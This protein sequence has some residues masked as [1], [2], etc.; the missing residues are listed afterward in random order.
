MNQAA[1][2][3]Q[4]MLEQVNQSKRVTKRLVSAALLTVML[5]GVSLPAN[6]VPYEKNDAGRVQT[7]ERYDQIQENTG[8]MNG[9]DAVDP[10][11]DTNE[12][13]AQALS[14]IAKRRQAQASDPLEPAR[15]AVSDMKDS[16][17]DAV[18]N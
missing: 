17:K 16:I 5:W 12:D 14:D 15:E 7:T 1:K 4:L 8:G 9:F 3:G 2:C 11:R 13:K 10:R 6:A 18:S